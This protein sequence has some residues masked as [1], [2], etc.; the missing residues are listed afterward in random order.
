LDNRRVY[1]RLPIAREGI[2]FV[3]GGCGATLA[4]VLLDL[5]SPACLLGG[6][7]LFT[8]FFFRDPERTPP[9]DPG[10]L[11]SPADGRVL[12]VVELDP[13][14]NPLGGPGKKVSIFMSLFS[15]H[16]NR[17]PAS[18]RVSAV[19]YHPG[20]FFSADLDKASVHNESN[21]IT[22]DLGPSGR[23][24]VIQIAG[25]IARRIACWV[26]EG[27]QV[28]RGHRFGLI[29]FGS[30]LEVLVPGRHRITVRAGQSVR[31]G[32]TIIGSL[33]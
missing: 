13:R 22:V 31:A 6:L 9:G 2:P 8:A 14:E 27:D 12:E 17:M 10:A 28:M 26:R 20:R 16:V 30:R 5:I 33:S 18:G 25:L 11:L 1:N 24:M 29:R 4:L 23:V 19:S 21:R 15:V 7:T 32:E 3:L